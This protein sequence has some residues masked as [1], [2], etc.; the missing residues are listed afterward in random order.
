MKDI[1]GQ[2][3][4]CLTAIEPTAERCRRC[5]VWLW[6]CDCGNIVKI[7]IDR[8]LSGNTR[9]CGCLKEAKSISRT[10]A[11]RAKNLVDG[12]NVGRIQS[13]A[14]PKNNKTGVRGVVKKRGK[15]EASITYQ[16]RGIY[17]GRFETL[18][19]AAQARKE[20]EELYF[21]PYRDGE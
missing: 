9:S 1:A 8:V 12:T 16:K 11:M 17:L 21:A 2:K 3:H 19:E 6:R 4:Y 13:K 7:S 18:D 15:Y 5:V 20:A 14:L 10:A